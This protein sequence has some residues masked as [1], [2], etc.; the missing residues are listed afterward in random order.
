MFTLKQIALR[1]HENH[2]GK[3]LCSLT[4]TVVVARFCDGA[5]LRSADLK[6]RWYILDRF[7]AVLWYRVNT[8]LAHHRSK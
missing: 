1:C 2:S 8:Y 7:C 5:K 6:S 3:G 4:R